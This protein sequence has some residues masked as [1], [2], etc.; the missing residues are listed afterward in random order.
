[1]MYSGAMDAP[2]SVTIRRQANRTA[3]AE[4]LMARR[5]ENNGGQD[6]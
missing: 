1:M 4:P 3:W 6:D 5:A 2:I